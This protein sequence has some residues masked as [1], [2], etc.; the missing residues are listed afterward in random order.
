M[1]YHTNM[2]HYCFPCTLVVCAV[3]ILYCE[4]FGCRCNHLSAQ[5]GRQP[6]SA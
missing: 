4:Y 2:V 6:C 1:L 3:H 5:S